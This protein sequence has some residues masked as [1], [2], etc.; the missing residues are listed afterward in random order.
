MMTMAQWATA[1]WDTSMTMMAMVDNDD[2]N[3]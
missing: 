3:G 2:G 1:Q